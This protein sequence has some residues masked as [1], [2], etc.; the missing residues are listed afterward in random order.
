M[1]VVFISYFTN[2]QKSSYRCEHRRTDFLTKYFN[3]IN[4]WEEL[5]FKNSKN[6]GYYN[7]YIKDRIW[8]KEN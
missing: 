4:V 1:L 2:H 8:E 6:I 7:T 3:T 5:I